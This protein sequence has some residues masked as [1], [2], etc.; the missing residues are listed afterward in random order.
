[1]AEINLL[2]HASTLMSS[3]NVIIN[4][5]I[6]PVSSPAIRLPRYFES[7][8][9]DEMQMADELSE[10]AIALPM[11]MSVYCRNGLRNITSAP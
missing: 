2:F 10:N 7:I 9:I 11:F 1:M 6:T 4:T 5:H 3:D 8:T